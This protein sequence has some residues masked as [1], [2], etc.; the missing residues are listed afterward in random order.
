LASGRTNLDTVGNGLLARESVFAYK[1]YIDFPKN[2]TALTSTEITT[3]QNVL[4][5]ALNAYIATRGWNS[6]CNPIATERRGNRVY[7]FVQYSAFDLTS[8]KGGF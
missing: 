6:Q 2:Y 3:Y 8:F 1:F 5:D 7:W 4:S